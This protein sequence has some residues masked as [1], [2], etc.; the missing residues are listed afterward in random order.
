LAWH[1][2]IFEQ[3]PVEHCGGS[4]N[5]QSLLKDEAVKKAALSWLTEQAVDLLMP[6][7]FMEVLNG[8]ILPSLGITTK[9]PARELPDIG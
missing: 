5:A 8:V 2:Q 3:L 7:K 9:R 1:Y 6:L 4:K